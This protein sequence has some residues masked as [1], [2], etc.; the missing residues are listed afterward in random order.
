VVHGDRGNPCPAPEHAR[1]RRT[2]GRPRSSGIA[3]PASTTNQFEHSMTIAHTSIFAVV[4]IS[5]PRP[6]RRGHQPRHLPA[7][8]VVF[9]QHVLVPPGRMQGTLLPMQ[10]GSALGSPQACSPSFLGWQFMHPVWQTPLCTQA[11][12]PDGHWEHG[13]VNPDLGS[14]HS[15][16]PAESVSGVHRCPQTPQFPSLSG[17]HIP[18]MDGQ[19]SSPAGQSMHTPSMQK[20]RLEG[21]QTPSH[22]SVS[23]RIQPPVVHPEQRSQQSTPRQ[24]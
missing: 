11:S 19:L 21:Q 22:S 4:H 17:M 6:P 9:A 13:I 16:A 8:H 23:C 14:T 12:G 3:D 7:M 15:A 10:C 5:P 1:T 2:R 24:L 20:G 18:C